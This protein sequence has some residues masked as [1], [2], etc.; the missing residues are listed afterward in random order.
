MSESQQPPDLLTL[1]PSIWAMS[2]SIQ[3]Q[4]YKQEYGRDYAEVDRLAAIE[5]QIA[6]NRLST[7]IHQSFCSKVDL[8][9]SRRT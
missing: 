8:L 1:L 3:A 9:F 5:E 2:M 6:I 4:A 7:R